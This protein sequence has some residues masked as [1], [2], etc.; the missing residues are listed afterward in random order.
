[1]ASKQFLIAPPTQGAENEHGHTINCKRN[2]ENIHRQ[3]TVV[4]PST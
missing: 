2:P 3:L 4:P 1:M